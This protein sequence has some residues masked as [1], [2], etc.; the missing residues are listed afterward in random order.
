MRMKKKHRITIGVLLV[1][2]AVILAMFAM[3]TVA[4]AQADDP[5]AGTPT[6]EPIPTATAAEIGTTPN[7]ATPPST[8]TGSTTSADQNGG[9]SS[10]DKVEAP[11]KEFFTIE[12]KSGKVFYL[13][14][15][16]KKSMDN[17]YLLTEVTE[18]DL[19]NFTEDEQEKDIFG[20]TAQPT[21]EPSPSATVSQK[22]Q[23]EATPPTTQPE[24]PQKSGSN[25]TIMMIGAIAVIA[26]VGVIVFVI[27]KRKAK[28]ALG[29]MDDLEDY[30]DTY[31]EDDTNEIEDDNGKD[32]EDNE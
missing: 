8:A 6:A 9:G 21:P 27:K 14:V 17:V 7:S 10:A 29:S 26:I 2:I 19:L 1:L 31:I 30:A 32:Q 16:N 25:N 20:G 24:Q 15:D 5:A 22:P 12:T 11:E 3:P 28:Q 18:N 13:V 23:E 4:A